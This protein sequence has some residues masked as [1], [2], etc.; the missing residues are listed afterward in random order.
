MQWI[1]RN[2]FTVLKKRQA[3]RQV[4]QVDLSSATLNY[5]AVCIPDRLQIPPSLIAIFLYTTLKGN[6]SRVCSNCSNQV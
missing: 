6:S 5:N 3:E 4:L 1:Y 2:R